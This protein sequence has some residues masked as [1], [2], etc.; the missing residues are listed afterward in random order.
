[1]IRLAAVLLILSVILGTYGE[2]VF[3]YAA[4]PGEVSRAE[5]AE[6]GDKNAVPDAANTEDGEKNAALDAA[7][8]EDEI[9]K[10]IEENRDTTPSVSISVFGEKEDICT[11]ISGKADRGND[12]LADEETVYEWGSI[13]KVLVWVSVMQL[14]EEGKL[15]LDADIREFL[16]KDFFNYLSYDKPITML[17]LMNHNAG[18]QSPY[19]DVETTDPEALMSLEKALKETEPA[20]IYAPGEVVAYSNW[21]AALAAYVVEKVSGM[22]YADYVNKNIFERL[23]M[24][25]TAIKPDLS[26]NQWVAEHRDKTH[27]Y[28]LEDGILNSMKECR[29]YI[30]IYPAGS[31]TGTM[32]DLVTFTKAFLCDSKDTPLFKEAGTLDEMLTPTIYFADGKTPRFCHGL[33]VDKYGNLVYGHGGNTTGFSSLMQFDPVSKTGFVVMV[34][35]RA[36]SIYR[37]RIPEIVFGKPDYSD[38]KTNDFKEVDFSGH[39]IMS[40]GTFEKGCF[41][42][43]SFLTDRFH[44]KLDKGEYTSNSGVKSITQ[45][46][47]NAAIFTLVNDEEKLYFFTTDEEGN[48]VRIEN[49]SI[50]FIKMSNSTFIINNIILISMIISLFVVMFLLVVHLIK[51]KAFKEGDL[52]RFKLVEINFG[53]AESILAAAISLLF[54]F[55]VQNEIVRAIFCIVAMAFLAVMIEMAVM[56]HIRWGKGKMNKVLILEDVCCV[57]ITVGFIYWKIYQF[58]GF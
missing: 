8:I 50:D 22:D 35:M 20:Q 23:G 6:D 14:Y 21:G 46:S 45:L 32:K 58:W 31:A 11:V 25:H 27:C 54:F 44:V 47:D 56:A 19:R 4:A 29:A 15:S 12:V 10:L 3:T 7:A 51:L 53:I 43:Y 42:V 5:G 1:M 9:N 34:N 57:L 37:S 49:T 55:G 40:G 17:N 52:R 48:I 38:L 33:E 16:P 2:K 30:H 26:D 36:N 39:Y 18:F 24:E 41:S 13:S 28:Y